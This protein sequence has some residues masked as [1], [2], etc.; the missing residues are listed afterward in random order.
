MPSRLRT[1]KD[2]VHFPT[3]LAVSLRMK[4]EH[5]LRGDIVRTG[6]MMYERGW[7]AANDGNLSAR[8][9][10][11]R[12]LVTPT[13]M[14]KA[15]MEPD[16]LLICDNDGNKIRGKRECSTEMAMHVAIYKLRPD[17]QAVVHAHP[18]F[19][20]GFA[21]AGRALNL[22]LMPELIITLGSVPLAEYGLPGTPALVEGMLP[23]IPKFDA[24]LLANHGAV[25]Y[26]ESILGAYGRME[27]LEH[28]ARITLV[29]EMLGGPKVLP[30]SEI[31]KLFDARKRYGVQTPNC[32]EPGSP[33]AAEDL[34]DP[35]ER[36]E[37]TRRELLMLLDEALLHRSTEDRALGRGTN[38][39]RSD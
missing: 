34:P 24:I 17:I 7:I 31:Q 28:L 8:L 26:G 5:Q 36:I 16:D 37:T 18:P 23:L 11:T 9:D 2:Q 19:S 13:G 14:C 1:L 22:G 35:G 27:T 6:Q 4:N 29:A 32:F 38:G 20:T 33:L 21:V 12:I 30:R 15:R 25:C 3:Q 10:D 39:H